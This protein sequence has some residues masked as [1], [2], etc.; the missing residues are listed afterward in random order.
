MAKKPRHSVILSDVVDVYLDG[1]SASSFG[2][3]CAVSGFEICIQINGRIG[4]ISVAPEK[5]VKLS[6]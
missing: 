3:V 2:R 1:S 6:I 5:L 4:R